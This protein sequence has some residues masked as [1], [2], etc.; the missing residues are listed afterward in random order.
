LYFSL[1][2]TSERTM[3][4]ENNRLSTGVPYVKT[5]SSCP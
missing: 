1:K 5:W 3:I 4:V 2:P